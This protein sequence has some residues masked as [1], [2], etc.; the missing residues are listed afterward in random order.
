MRCHH[1]GV[2]QIILPLKELL[3]G[4]RSLLDRVLLFMTEYQLLHSL[5]PVGIL[6]QIRIPASP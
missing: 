3:L 1:R 5:F 2:V 6:L 4:C